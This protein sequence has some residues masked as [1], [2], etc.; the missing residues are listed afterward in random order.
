MGKVKILIVDDEA[1]I[2][3]VMARA[4]GGKYECLTASGGEEALKLL[5]EEPGIRL[6]LSDI[7]MPG[8]DGV[9]LLKRAKAID[10]SLVCILLT[11]YGTVELA[12]A[13]MKDGADDFL[14]K[15]I[16]DLDQLELRVERALKTVKLEEEVK[17]LKTRLAEKYSLE[18]FTGSSEAMQKVYARIRQAAKSNANVLIEGPSGTGKE[19]VAQALHNLSARSKG[20]FVAVECAALS[21]TLLES[22]LFGH[23][24]GAFTDAIK[25]RQGR[26][27]LADG[28]TLFLDEISEIDASTQ[29]KLLRVLETRTFQRVGGSKD[30]KTDI[31][32]VAAT[33][34]D[35]RQYVAEGKF[36]EDLYYRLNVIDIH[37]PAL[38]DRPGDIALLVNRFL[39]EFCRENG[40][41]AKVVEPEAMRALENYDWPGNVRE[42]RNAVEKMVVL[43]EGER[44]GMD[45]LPYEI[46]HARTLE[47]SVPAVMAGSGVNIKEME[48]AKI[49]STL[50]RFHYNKTRA[51]E[52]LGIS[53]RT[54]HRK[55]NEWK[56]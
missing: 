32:I 36:R 44:L 20:P 54:L 22:E 14:T 37:L 26:F 5:R 39:K 46:A 12:V 24:K 43:S 52:E 23:E 42:L 28:G 31:R 3:A 13:A 29:V 17:A 49:L 21:S 11:A 55:L 45:D 30:I 19:L 56:S 41:K 9:E 38:K 4:L 51:A 1:A 7:R 48:K 53:R 2:R 40:V 16:T 10:K 25:E 15:P 27:E 8:M 50:E 35:L 34:R 33:N 6:M 47:A 18:N